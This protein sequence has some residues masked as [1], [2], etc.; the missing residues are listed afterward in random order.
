MKEKV[1]STL[2]TA[3]N[4]FM[5][6]FTKNRVIVAR[7]SGIRGGVAG[8]AVRTGVGGLI[9]DALGKSV[10]GEMSKKRGEELKELDP[11]EILKSSRFNFEVPY[12]NLE[13]VEMQQK[14]NKIKIIANEKFGMI[15]KKKKDKK[16]K[17]EIFQYET[18]IK[19]LKG[20]EFEDQVNSLR[21]VLSDKLEIV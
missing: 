13:K 9:G 11:E 16:T 7:V 20:P 5:L 2:Y 8:A 6:A 14:K 19:K 4:N 21:S 18:P 17:K 1:I 10:E 12:N 15:M 3:D